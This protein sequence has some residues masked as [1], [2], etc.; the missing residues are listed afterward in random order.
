MESVV[1][2]LPLVGYEHY[3]IYAGRYAES[4]NER[5]GYFPGFYGGGYGGQFDQDDGMAGIIASNG[6]RTL[7]YI[8]GG[9]YHYDHTDA[10]NDLYVRTISSSGVPGAWQFVQRFAPGSQYEFQTLHPI[11]SGLAIFGTSANTG[12]Y[13]IERGTYE[14]DARSPVVLP[15]RGGYSLDP[16]SLVLLNPGNGT[17]NS[18]MNFTVPLEGA[19]ASSHQRGSLFLVGEIPESYFSD[20]PS[21]DRSGIYFHGSGATIMEF[22]PRT[23]YLRNA[24]P[25][26]TDTGSGGQFQP[27]GGTVFAPS[28]FF[29]TELFLQPIDVK[30]AAWVQNRLMLT[31]HAGYLTNS[32]SGDPN[33]YLVKFNPDPSSG[34]AFIER[35]ERSTGAHTALAEF[36][37]GSPAASVSLT[38][39][40]GPIDDFTIDP[41]FA[42]LAFSQQTIDSGFLIPLYQR[43]FL[44]TSFDPYACYYD[45]REDGV[46]ASIPATLA[47][48]TN[49]V[50]GIGHVTEAIRGP[51][52]PDFDRGY[53]IHPCSGYNETPPPQ[54]DTILA[55]DL[56]NLDLRIRGIREYYDDYF[57][58]LPNTIGYGGGYGGGYAG[59]YFTDDGLAAAVAGADLLDAERGNP[60]SAVVFYAFGG[61]QDANPEG[62]GLYEAYNQLYSTY[63]TLYPEYDLRGYYEFELLEDYTPSP[64]NQ[65]NYGSPALTGLTYLPAFA[66]LP[67]EARGS[68]DS[69]GLYGVLSPGFTRMS[70]D[71]FNPGSELVDVQTDFDIN[72][73]N[74]LVGF[75]NFGVPL[76]GA[77]AAS[78]ERG[79]LFTVANIPETFLYED[80]EGKTRGF[81]A[82]YSRAILEFDPRNLYLANA[83]GSPHPSDV[84]GGDNDNALSIRS[85]TYVDPNLESYYYYDLNNYFAPVKGA[86]FVQGHL[87]VTAQAYILNYLNDDFARGNGA[88]FTDQTFYFNP[89][90]AGTD[91]DPHITD[92]HKEYGIKSALSEAT[93]SFAA[94]PQP[95]ALTPDTMT[96]G[97]LNLA[98]VNE[99]FARVA[100][101][102][103]ALDSGVARRI[104][105]NHFLA[106]SVDAVNC[107]KTGVFNIDLPN[108]LNDNV[109]RQNGFGR[110]AYQLR[111][112]LDAEHA[113]SAQGTAHRRAA[114]AKVASDGKGHTSRRRPR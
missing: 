34:G 114:S 75:A 53:G 31:V 104:F 46:F 93:N 51:I 91:L 67:R 37:S 92:V 54:F 61:V 109:D 19:L 38:V 76:E 108:R 42:R 94:L 11:I 39:M 50:D 69:I 82:I 55:S 26:F 6:T 102:Q 90:A 40:P 30:G 2:D 20:R 68:S 85:G 43:H 71:R 59:G 78:T 86:A 107:T 13:G 32:R 21:G 56:E 77:L 88:S 17:L 80:R 9:S 48:Y 63:R 52:R 5:L 36:V 111:E 1:G 58:E 89:D 103:Q 4:S 29:S 101:S 110:T 62:N 15:D 25:Q 113:C 7:Y 74:S 72:T 70:F 8:R 35:I 73:P 22:D 87:V 64:I 95:R 16:S 12:L 79:S 66:L 99:L 23:N 44:E 24:W 65:P 28:D 33:P 49:V 27:S 14:Y 3:D 10:A 106:T 81:D 18:V 105:E 112:N 57:G 84:R 96:K 47:M 41:S 83:W 97:E 100:Y 98:G 45:Y 60:Y